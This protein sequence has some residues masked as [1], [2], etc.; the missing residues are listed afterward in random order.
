[1]KRLVVKIGSNILTS[2]DNGLDLGRIQ[3]IADDISSVRDAGYEVVVVSSGA[4]AAGM[5]KL[6]LKEKPKDIILKQASAA[7]GQ[8]SLMW[9]YE[10]SFSAH[11]KKV[12][13]IL[14]TRDDFADRKRYINSRNTLITLLSYKVIP[15]INENDTVATDEIRFGD[16]DHLASLVSGLIDAERFIILSDVD[17]LF[18]DDPGR[19]PGARLIEVVEEITPE[20]EEKA[21]GSGSA[22]GT[23]GMFSKLLA[24]KR[25][26]HHGIT[27][28]ILNGRTKGAI[29]S[30]LKG[31]HHG[32]EFKPQETRLSSKKGWI[33][34]ACR[35]KGSVI[36]D[37][38][39]VRALK[40][41]GKSL[42]PSGIVSLSG[43]FEA[44]DA[45]YCVDS[46]GNRIAKGLANYSS[47]EVEKIKGKKTSEIEGV[48]G[49]RY[50]D[51]VIHRDNLAL[52]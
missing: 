15:V 41:G 51:E 49:Y 20:I 12:A 3:S 44:G 7:V 31:I 24:A 16:N 36:I 23:G 8:S 33:A 10:K 21:G 18:T 29:S 40:Q 9:A 39:A 32:T 38:G 45:I 14:L 46:R 13:Q 35:T 52:L 19:N 5:K 4:V 47:S 30:L 50:S 17:G 27:V 1:L 22:V 48:L 43:S 11:G 42:L 26:V 37:D 2:E 28:N 25:A 34:Y 6:E